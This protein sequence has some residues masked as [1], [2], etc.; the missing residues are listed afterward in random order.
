MT[1]VIPSWVFLILFFYYLIGLVL[2]IPLVHL[3]SRYI[4]PRRTGW[5]VWDNMSFKRLITG[6]LIASGVFWPYMI[7][8]ISRSEIRRR[9]RLTRSNYSAKV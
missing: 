1:I 3:S 9:R 4:S 5:A 2:Y 8:D 6:S 7:F